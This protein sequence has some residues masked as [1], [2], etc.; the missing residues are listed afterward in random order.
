M[1]PP[2]NWIDPM[3]L[4]LLTAF[5]GG[6]LYMLGLRSEKLDQPTNWKWIGVGILTLAMLAG[7]GP[8]WQYVGPGLDSQLYRDA[9]PGRRMLISHLA[10]FLIP[11]A[12]VLWILIYEFW[13]RRRPVKEQG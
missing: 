12:G 11:L 9:A 7:I 5:F 1:Q 4:P 3:V 2:A 13:W 10:G 8:F 6:L